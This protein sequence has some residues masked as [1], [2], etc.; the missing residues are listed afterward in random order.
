[1]HELLLLLLLLS[2][3]ETNIPKNSKALIM[4]APCPRKCLLHH[5]GL[6]NDQTIFGN[7]KFAVSQ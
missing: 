3:V 6:K 2:R 7:V 4:L 1:M 5:K